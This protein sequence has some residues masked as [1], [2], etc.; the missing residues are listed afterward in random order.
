MK[1]YNY[2]LTLSLTHQILKGWEKATQ[3]CDG[4]P[5]GSGAGGEIKTDYVLVPTATMVGKLFN[6][7]LCNKDIF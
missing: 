1:T 6:L 7:Y 2:A 3:Y 4:G 5:G